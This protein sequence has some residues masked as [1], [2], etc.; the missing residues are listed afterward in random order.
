MKSPYDGHD[1][2]EWDGITEEIIERYPIS[3]NDIIKSVKEAWDKT[4]QTKIGASC[5][6]HI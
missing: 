3:E 2:Q 1:I 5:I 6:I 4:K